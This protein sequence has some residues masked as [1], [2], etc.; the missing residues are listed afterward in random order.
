MRVNKTLAEA[1]IACADQ[2]AQGRKSPK[3][4]LAAFPEYKEELSSLLDLAVRIKQVLVPVR[5]GAV[6]R[7]ALKSRL[8]ETARQKMTPR[9]AIR[10]P[11]PRRRLILISA[12][13]GSALSVV[14]GVVAA[15][16]LR[17]RAMHGKAA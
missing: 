8:V 11:F 6:Y 17:N 1:V 2:L 9:I 10:N 4:L 16:L 13:I 14:V 15:L 3:E 7:E 5:P 12:A